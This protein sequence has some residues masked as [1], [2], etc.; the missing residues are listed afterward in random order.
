MKK[1][2][3]LSSVL[4]LSILLTGC[5][6]H[7]AAKHDAENMEWLRQ[8]QQQ[9]LELARQ[10]KAADDLWVKNNQALIASNKKRIPTPELIACLAKTD[11]MESFTPATPVPACQAVAE[12]AGQLPGSEAFEKALDMTVK[13]RQRNYYAIEANRQKSADHFQKMHDR[14]P[15]STTYAGTRYIDAGPGTLAKPVKI[16][17][18]KA[19]CLP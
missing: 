15:C 5:A 11:F 16:Y 4:L 13:E 8:Q 19:G 12:A 2:F 7:R 9:R 10:Q 17:N 18:V 6:G 1:I 14:N 3:T